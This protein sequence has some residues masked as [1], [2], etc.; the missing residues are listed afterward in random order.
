MGLDV[1]LGRVVVRLCRADPGRRCSG[2]K[3]VGIGGQRPGTVVA[4]GSGQGVLHVGLGELVLD[5]LVAGDGPTEGVAFE[6]IG[7]GHLQRGIRAA[8]LFPREQHRG[9]V[10]QALGRRP[11]FADGT[12]RF[13]RTVVER[14]LS[15]RPGR[16][17]SANRCSGHAVKFGE[18]QARAI[19]GIGSRHDDGEVRD[20][21]VRNRNLD[22]RNAIGGCN[23][24]QLFWPWLPGAFAEGEGSDRIA[25]RE[26]G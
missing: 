24:G 22:P 16:V 3:F 25:R 20:V 11:S 18:E 12:Q 1:L 10:E 4:V 21:S 17:Q 15:M 9:P 6:R 2:G 26:L 23:R 5:R 13:R 14:D 7:L 19:A 8:D